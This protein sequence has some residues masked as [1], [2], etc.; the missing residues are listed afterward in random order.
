MLSNLTAT[1][2]TLLAVS[3]EAVNLKTGNPAPAVPWYGTRSQF[4]TYFKDYCEYER[5]ESYT[6]LGGIHAWVT[7]MAVEYCENEFADREIDRFIANH[8]AKED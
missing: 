6:E 5:L 8:L 7:T 3:T 4:K 1:I 2:L